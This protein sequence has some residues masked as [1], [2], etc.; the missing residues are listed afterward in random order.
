V[1]AGWRQ[2]RTRDGRH[3]TREPLR[4]LQQVS[5]AGKQ[6]RSNVLRTCSKRSRCS[7][8]TVAYLSLRART[9]RVRGYETCRSSRDFDRGLGLP[10]SSEACIC[11]M[12][13][14][15]PWASSAKACFSSVTCCSWPCSVA[16]R[17]ENSWG[18]LAVRS[19]RRQVR[20]GYLCFARV[21]LM[22]GN[23]NI[24]EEGV[25]LADD[26]RDLLGEVARVHGGSGR[27]SGRVGEYA[28]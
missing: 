27:A 10:S 4:V 24:V 20:A 12:A 17:A 11:L 9:Q 5:A 3:K 8:L 18:Q 21:A 22:A 2:S 7:L 14:I 25:Q 16:E 1:A 23:A 26:G 28:L 19:G 15:K 13:S 6:G